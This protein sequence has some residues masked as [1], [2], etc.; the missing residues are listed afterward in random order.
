MKPYP[1]RRIFAGS[2][3]ICTVPAQ[4]ATSACGSGGRATASRPFRKLA[5]TVS[6][7]LDGILAWIILRIP[8][9]VLEGMNNKVKPI[10]HRAFGFRTTWTYIANMYHCCPGLPLPYHCLDGNP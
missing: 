2:G 9:G 8:N 10:S 7:H 6:T 5:E 4:K 3:P 1:P